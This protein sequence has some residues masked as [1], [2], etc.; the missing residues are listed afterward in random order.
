MILT[1]GPLNE[2]FNMGQISRSVWKF[3]GSK[4]A[5]GRYTITTSNIKS[6]LRIDNVIPADAG[7][8]KLRVTKVYTIGKKEERMMSECEMDLTAFYRVK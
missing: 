5:G 3:K 4:I 6:T 1:C 2:D 7:K 8:F